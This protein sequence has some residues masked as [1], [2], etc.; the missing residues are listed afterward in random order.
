ML[1]TS[2]KFVSTDASSA[3]K[4]RERVKSNKGQRYGLLLPIEIEGVVNEYT[5][6]FEVKDSWIKK[7]ETEEERPY[8]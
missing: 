3:N 5:F 7:W 8:Y 1:P 6:W 4:F 2:D